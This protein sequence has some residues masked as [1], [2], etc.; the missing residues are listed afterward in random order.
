M[1][2]EPAEAR[3]RPGGDNRMLLSGL[4]RAHRLRCYWC[5]EPHQFRALQVDHLLPQTATGPQLARLAKELGQHQPYD[6][7]DP[8][9]LA[10]ICGPCN[11]EKRAADFTGTPRLLS[12]LR[13]TRRVRPDVVQHVELLLRSGDLSELLLQFQSLDL[14]GPVDRESLEEVAPM[15]VERIASIDPSLIRHPLRRTVQ[16]ATASPRTGELI[17]VEVDV[18]DAGRRNLEALERFGAP[19]EQWPTVLTEEFGHELDALADSCVPEAEYAAERV[20]ETFARVGVAN[21]DLDWANPVITIVDVG[22][23]VDEAINLVLHGE[24]RLQVVG[25]GVFPSPDGSG[26]DDFPVDGSVVAG[27][28]AS[29][30]ADFVEDAPWSDFRAEGFRPGS[31]LVDLDEPSAAPPFT[32]EPP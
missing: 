16:R 5:A 27:F 21:Y 8:Y 17:M 19:I 30:Q 25:S 11:I 1:T 29:L 28:T 12:L 7:H 2:T 24:L 18:P 23:D 6:V 26:L 9:N 20:I 10:P 3:Y 22:F 4:W 31:R 13:K 15:F 14:A 32:P